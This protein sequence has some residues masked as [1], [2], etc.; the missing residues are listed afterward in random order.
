VGLDLDPALGL[1]Q[2]LPLVCLEEVTGGMTTTDQPIGFDHHELGSVLRSWWML[3]VH[4]SH[5]GTAA[6]S[7]GKRS[8]RSGGTTTIAGVTTRPDRIEP[9]SIEPDSIEP[10]SIEP[11]SKDWTWVLERPCEDCGFDAAALE[12]GATGAAIRA[13]APRWAE[14]LDGAGVGTRPGPSVWSPL[15]YAC[16]VRDVFRLFDTRLQLMLDEDDPL[17]ANW[18]QDETAVSERYGEQDPEIVGRELADA[19]AGVAGRFDSI[20][21]DQ[22]AR[23]GRRSDGASFTIDSFARYFLHDPTHHLWDVTGR[24]P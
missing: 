8:A 18:D 23:R 4:R 24:Q 16:H 11:D 22:W 5:H 14:I 3:V 1:G 19:A 21:P 12:V 20:T 2:H 15:E 6:A 13:M 10:D 7:H 9:D 17:F